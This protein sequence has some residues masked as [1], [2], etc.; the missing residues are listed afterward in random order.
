MADYP[1]PDFP[2]PD[3]DFLTPELL[4]H[5]VDVRGM[6]DFDHDAD[7]DAYFRRNP[8][9]FGKNKRPDSVSSQAF[10]ESTTTKSVALKS[11]SSPKP[12]QNCD[13]DSD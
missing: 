8:I 7:W 6:D 3:F 1:D 9:F 11:Q 10:S 13:R 5:C 12:Q 4:R 2:D